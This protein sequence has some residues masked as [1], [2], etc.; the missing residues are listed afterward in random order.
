MIE[1][2]SNAFLIVVCILL[3]SKVAIARIA[4]PIQEIE[5]RS[6]EVNI[7]SRTVYN[8]KSEKN[9]EALQTYLKA[10]DKYVAIAGRP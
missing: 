3:S 6:V 5:P 8:N 7:D 2:K 4:D 10:L 9:S 1:G